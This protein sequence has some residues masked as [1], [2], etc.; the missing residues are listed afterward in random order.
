MSKCPALAEY[1]T[2]HLDAAWQG[3]TEFKV[4][5]LK[6]GTQTARL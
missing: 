4:M 3:N 5:S 6:E 1:A 2:A